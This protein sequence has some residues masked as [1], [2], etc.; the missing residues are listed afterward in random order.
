M[1]LQ[2][3][4]SVV[5]NCL[6]EQEWSPQACLNDKAAGLDAKFVAAVRADVLNLTDDALALMGLKQDV[7]TI[8]LRRLAYQKIHSVNVVC[9]N[10]FDRIERK[11]N[12][13]L[14]ATFAKFD[15]DAWAFKVLA[16]YLYPR[17]MVRFN[18]SDTSEMISAKRFL[19][20]C[21]EK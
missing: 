10:T 17:I 1:S 13:N 7:E 6:V 4:G 18:D 11:I 21:L 3:E 9:P 20:N 5:E 16:G 19:H 12:E 8:V 2:F 14:S 15:K